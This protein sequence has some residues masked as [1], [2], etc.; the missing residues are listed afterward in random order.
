MGRQRALA[1]RAKDV[2]L[3]GAQ[4][5]RL[6]DAQKAAISLME[7]E[8]RLVPLLDA[9]PIQSGV[10]AELAGL[11]ARFRA[12]GGRLRRGEL[13]GPARAQLP[14]LFE[15]AR[16][17][18][19]R[20]EASA[21]AFYS[22]VLAQWRRAAEALAVLPAADRAAVRDELARVHGC[23][24]PAAAAGPGSPTD[25]PTAT[26]EERLAFTVRKPAAPGGDLAKPFAQ[27][28]AEH[29]HR[30]GAAEDAV[31]APPLP[32]GASRVAA[33]AAKLEAAK[34][35][36]RPMAPAARPRPARDDEL[37]EGYERNLGRSNPFARLALPALAIRR[38]QEVPPRPRKKAYVWATFDYAGQQAGD[39][40]FRRGDRIQVLMQT[41]S[42]DDWWTGRVGEQVG[43]FPAN[44]T[45]H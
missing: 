44:Y 6:F 31:A 35:V 25:V 22:G 7:L 33:L 36:F 34:I 20:C 15:Q 28:H 41:A 27:L 37:E 19:G 32:S 3:G 9:W 40:C 29:E 8:N 10:P 30:A 2:C 45:H 12:V 26:I 16:D 39:L 38:K 17:T 5:Q 21:R 18:V 43:V 13:R 1:E 14:E 11:Q 23:V 42:Q 4:P 24:E